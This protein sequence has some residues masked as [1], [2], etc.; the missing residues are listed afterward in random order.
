MAEI[1]KPLTNQR[2]IGIL[3]AAAAAAAAAQHSRYATA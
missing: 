3:A 2:L 1:E